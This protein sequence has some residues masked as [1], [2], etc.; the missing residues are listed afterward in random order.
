MRNVGK[1]DVAKNM[2]GNRSGTVVRNA[3][4]HHELIAGVADERC[5]DQ[6]QVTRRVVR[7]TGGYRSHGRSRT[8]SQNPAGA[9]DLPGGVKN[10][11]LGAKS[12]DPARSHVHGLIADRRRAEVQGIDV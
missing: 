2:Y 7:T 5:F 3:R 1:A 8:D 4:V 10:S 12:Q 11:A 6:I 9:S